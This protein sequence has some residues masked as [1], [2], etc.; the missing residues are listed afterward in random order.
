MS[1]VGEI[2]DGEMKNYIKKPKDAITA[3]VM[4]DLKSRSDRGIQK[5]N[6]T[7]HENNKDNFMNHLYEELLD[8]AQ[9]CKKELSIIPMIQAL[10]NEYPNNQ[11]LGEKIREIFNNH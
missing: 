8:A 6:T 3:S 7:L 2:M 4:E 5:Y 11:L 10:I 1:I 9:Y